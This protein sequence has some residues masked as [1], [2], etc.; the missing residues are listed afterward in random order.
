MLEGVMAMELVVEPIQQCPRVLEC[1]ASVVVRSATLA[2]AHTR[3]RERMTMTWY[4]N[5]TFILHNFIYI[6]IYSYF[7]LRLAYVVFL[8]I[9]LGYFSF[10]VKYIVT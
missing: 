4:A 10:I 2:L 8:C 3:R 7:I 9:F 6:Y 5:V 1:V